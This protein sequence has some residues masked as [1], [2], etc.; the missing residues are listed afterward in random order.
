M[1]F[2]RWF[3]YTDSPTLVCHC[4][5]WAADGS[6]ERTIILNPRSSNDESS[7][8][9]EQPKPS[10]KSHASKQAPPRPSSAVE[11]SAVERPTISQLPGP[12]DPSIPEQPPGGP[13]L[14]TLHQQ[15]W[16]LAHA[17]QH[18]SDPR[19]AFY[20]PSEPQHFQPQQ[21]IPAHQPD[22][23]GLSERT[24]DPSSYQNDPPYQQT[25]PPGNL[26]SQLRISQQSPTQLQAAVQQHFAPP[27]EQ[28]HHGY[29]SHFQQPGP[30]SHFGSQYVDQR[31]GGPQL[32][33]AQHPALQHTPMPYQIPAPQPQQSGPSY[34]SSPYGSPGPS[35]A[36]AASPARQP[37]TLPAHLRPSRSSDGSSPGA[38]PQTSARS[39][40][41]RPFRSADSSPAG[42][43]AQRNRALLSASIA[44]ERVSSSRF[45]Q[46]LV[47][48]AVS[49]CHVLADPEGRE[50]MFFVFP[51][52]SVR[53][54]GSYTLKFS[55]VDVNW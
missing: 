9:E 51:D 6:E 25:Q 4:S 1:H 23:Y 16:D 38:S 43:P 18:G 14:G 17:A 7:S 5:L 48:T 2:W 47:G 21:Y 15:A 36:A 35:S 33:H 37:Q 34:E 49:P 11:S 24:A 28:Y 19:R 30:S 42:T 41:S 10:R 54:Q 40:P 3:S 50:G 12:P 32:P 20:Q 46:S 53:P 52:L 8:E 22:T 45:C 27:Q 44:Q 26:L 13:T 55:L 29:S 39:T 31:A